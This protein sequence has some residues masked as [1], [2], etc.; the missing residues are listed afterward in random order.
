MVNFC[1]DYFNFIEVYMKILII[2]FP[3]SGTSLSLRILDKNPQISRAF[4]ETKLLRK[5][6]TKKQLIKKYPQFS[7]NRSCAEKIIYEGVTFGSKTKDTPIMYCDMWNEY[8][9]E[10]A[11]ILHVIR[12]PY[13]VWN[14]L[15][16][17]LYLKRHWEHLI[18]K[19]LQDYFDCI[20]QYPLQIS[21]YENSMIYKYEDLILDNKNMVKKIYKF[22]GLPHFD[23]K[24][25]MRTNK[26][27]WYKEIGHRINNEPK[28]KQYR[29]EFNQIFRERIS[30]TLDIL[31]EIPGPVYE[32]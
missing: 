5:N 17:K 1:S 3:R 22:C 26:V 25:R 13:D 29:K 15:L 10:Q 24:E 21:K 30:E 7:E 19:K 18:I 32:K 14:S 6:K 16:L 8:F 9:G 23:Y 12:H 2:S 4:F 31:N 27:F 11:K 28:L 20:K